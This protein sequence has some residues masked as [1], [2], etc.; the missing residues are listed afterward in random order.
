MALAVIKKV[1]YAIVALFAGAASGL[2]PPQETEFADE[3]ADD[4]SR[5]GS[6]SSREDADERREQILG[7]DGE[8]G[9]TL[10]QEEAVTRAREAMSR[11]L[12]RFARRGRAQRTGSDDDDKP[13]RRSDL[14]DYQCTMTCSCK[15]TKV[16][17]K[18]RRYVFSRNYPRIRWWPDTSYEEHVDVDPEDLENMDWPEVPSPTKF[19]ETS[20]QEATSTQEACER[21]TESEGSV[22]TRCKDYC[23]GYSYRLS[24]RAKELP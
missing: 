21:M 15:P 19:D 8:A 9:T 5:H 22:D 18:T 20:R 4:S 16:V 3:G 1:V 10:L 17:Q 14:K 23:K 11:Q 2:L 13:T 7:S 24:C 6:G 12:Q